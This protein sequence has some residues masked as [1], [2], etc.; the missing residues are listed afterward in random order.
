MP[1]HFIISDTHFN[2]IDIINYA[3]RPFNSTKKMD[4]YMIAQWNAVVSSND[5]VYH[6][7]DF[8]LDNRAEIESFVERLNGHIILIKGNHDT[9]PNAIYESAGLTVLKCS[10]LNVHQIGEANG[11]PIYATHKPPILTHPFRFDRRIFFGHIHQRI[12]CIEGTGKNIC[13]CVERLNYRPLCLEDF[14]AAKGVISLKFF[15]IKGNVVDKSQL[16]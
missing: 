3:K 8:G 15:G 16:I 1:K 14:F 7:G 11:T 10:E 5:I 12:N 6:L 2:H 13:C 4:D 9:L